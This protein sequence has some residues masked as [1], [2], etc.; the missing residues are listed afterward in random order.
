MLKSILNNPYHILGVYSNSPKKEQVANKGKMQ[1]FLRVNKSMPFK[2]DLQGILPDIHR[3]QELVDYADSELALSTGQIRHA[4]FWFIN[5]TQIDNIAFN[6]LTGGDM[7]S[8][9]EIWRKSLNCYSL[10]NLFVCYLIKEDYRAALNTAIALY[11]QFAKEFVAAIDENANVSVND[12]IQNIIDTISGEGVDLLHISNSISDNVW[13]TIIKEK[14]VKPIIEKLDL[15]VS[16][17]KSTKKKGVQARLA[18]G[19]KLKIDTKQLLTTLQEV[20]PQSDTRYQIIADKVSQEVLQCSIDYYNDTDDDDS[21]VK[22]LPLCEYAKTVAVG[23]EAKQRCEKNYAVIKKAYEDMPPK[24]V[25]KESKEINELLAWYAV[26]AKTS[27]NALELLKKAQIPLVTIKEKM[28]K[29][30][31]YYLE[32]SSILG[33]AALGNVIEEVNSA[34]KEETNNP[35]EGLFGTSSVYS[36]LSDI[37]GEHE[38]RRQRALRLKSALHDA[39]Q[40]IV[41]I[42]LLDK[43][44]VFYK[45]RY[46]PNRNTLYS[47]ISGL[48]GFERPDEQYIIKGCAYGV[49]ANKKFFYS[50]SEYYGSCTTKSDYKG[51]LQS[52]PSGS[53][54]AEANKK[55]AEIEER[56][57]Q[58]RNYI[59]AAI[60]AISILF[61]IISVSGKD[62]ER[63]KDRAEPAYS[64]SYYDN[65]NSNELEEDEE[66]DEEVDYQDDE[67]DFDEEDFEDNY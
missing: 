9:I 47:I 30:N 12:L 41:Y 62:N 40:T 44:D 63:T 29:T 56:E 46:K 13:Q 34:Q 33:S 10:Q 3:T 61:F 21:P 31:S 54:I 52:F 15:L 53:H 26:Q 39:W 51:Y 27:K 66:T 8:A 17:A 58:T 64:S 2:L 4:Q 57:R 50:D 18:A 20:L 11:N 14:K 38:R 60:I 1:A 49:T 5:K 36:R 19:N 42:D 6:H 28:G 59:I 24:E 55:L 37:I 22:T 65:S 43:T 7:D 48:Q 25:A 23:S 32:I 45:N 67:E 16:E 35:L